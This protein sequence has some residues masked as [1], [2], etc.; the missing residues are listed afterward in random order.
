MHARPKPHVLMP[1]LPSTF[2][3]KLKISRKFLS[4]FKAYNFYTRHQ[5]AKVLASNLLR[6]VLISLPSNYSFKF[7]VISCIAFQNSKL[8]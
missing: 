1:Q 4:T 6:I 5:N 8:L 3:Q 2:A 7:E